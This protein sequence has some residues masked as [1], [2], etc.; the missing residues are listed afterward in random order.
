MKKKGFAVV[1]LFLQIFLT[2]CSTIGTKETD[3][4]VV[5]AVTAVLSLLLLAGYCGLICPC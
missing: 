4:S 2:G 1:I 3:L 5:Y